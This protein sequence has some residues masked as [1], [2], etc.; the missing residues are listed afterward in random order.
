MELINVT[1]CA[2]RNH[3]VVSL[4]SEIAYEVLQQH[5][6]VGLDV[7]TVHVGVEQNDGEGQDEDGVWVMK[8]LHHVWVAHA[9]ALTAR[10]T[11]LEKSVNIPAR[12]RRCKR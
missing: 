9:V 1:Y 5:L 10:V 7:G 4:T 8:L 2:W 11:E 12:S 3:N 6:A